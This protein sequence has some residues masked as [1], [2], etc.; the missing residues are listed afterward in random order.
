MLRALNRVGIQPAKVAGRTQYYDVLSCMVEQGV[1]ASML[2]EAFINPEARDEVRIAWPFEPW[3][4]VIR[5]SPGLRGQAARAV[6]RFLVDSVL[7]DARYPALD[8]DSEALSA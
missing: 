3:R 4:I 1:G 2:C 5:R 8:P 7:T 6:E